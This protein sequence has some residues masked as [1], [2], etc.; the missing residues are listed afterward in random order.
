MP[1]I[2]KLKESVYRQ[3][4]IDRLAEITGVD[5]ETLLKPAPA[6]RKRDSGDEPTA[7]AAGCAG[8]G[9]TPAYG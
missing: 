4:M 1:L 3:L 8:F 2:R 6:A 9:T 7:L 5:K